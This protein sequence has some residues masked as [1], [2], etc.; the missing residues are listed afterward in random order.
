MA[1]LEVS[2]LKKIYTTRFGSSAKINSGFVIIARAT[3]ALCFCP[4]DTSY[5]YL[6]LQVNRKAGEYNGSKERLL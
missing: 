4:P 2:N 6:L 3:A 5:G 1:I